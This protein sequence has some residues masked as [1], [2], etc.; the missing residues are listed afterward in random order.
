M[1]R[2]AL[3]IK[4]LEAAGLSESAA[5]L[6][7][8]QKLYKVAA[9]DFSKEIEILQQLSSIVA[10][11]QD[12]PLK[13]IV[14]ENLVFPP[15]SIETSRQYIVYSGEELTNYSKQEILSIGF[16]NFLNNFTDK[17]MSNRL[18]LL[19]G[20][21]YQRYERVIETL[22]ELSKSVK[23][24]YK[25]ILKPYTPKQL[26]TLKSQHI[27][28]QDIA[29][30]LRRWNG[31]LDNLDHFRTVIAEKYVPVLANQGGY[32]QLG[33]EF[34]P[35]PE[36][37]D[38]P[39]DLDEVTEVAPAKKTEEQKL[40][41]K[42]QQAL[43]SP[44]EEL[45]D[46]AD[47]E[48]DLI[49]KKSSFKSA[50][51]SLSLIQTLKNLTYDFDQMRTRIDGKYSKLLNIPIEEFR[52]LT[53]IDSLLKRKSIVSSLHRVAEASDIFESFRQKSKEYEI[54]H[55]YLQLESARKVAKAVISSSA[56]GY[57]KKQ[58]RKDVFV[59]FNPNQVLDAWVYLEN[60]LSIKYESVV[61]SIVS[62]VAHNPEIEEAAKVKLEPDLQKTYSEAI[63][64]KA[65]KELTKVINALRK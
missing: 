16:S 19:A 28:K 32:V 21:D 23:D 26:S 51:I 45:E 20:T 13:H 9:V 11:L 41:E 25:K 38:D 14:R 7:S 55:E 29:A 35:D 22:K 37:H 39:A 33:E 12:K 40:N 54:S 52:K 2:L 15:Y 58:K 8:V 6:R 48:Q 44:E 57:I 42:S 65:L 36:V 60:D 34:V 24:D 31:A 3:V 18:E 63:D 43:K 17:Y 62:R 27:T 1:N 10:H 5:S 64:N 4:S 50:S 30:S 46:D 61:R 47:L 59:L 49:K 53:N 56:I